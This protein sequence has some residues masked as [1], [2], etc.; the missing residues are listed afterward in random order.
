[1][2]LGLQTLDILE[3]DFTIHGAKQEVLHAAGPRKA[4][5]RKWF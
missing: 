3:V 5:A 1:M 4:A 2:E